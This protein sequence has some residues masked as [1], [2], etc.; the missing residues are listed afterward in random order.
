MIKSIKYRYVVVFL[1]LVFIVL[2]YS[3]SFGSEFDG[4]FLTISTFTFSIF[5][6]FFISKQG[7][8]QTSV[9][10]KVS[11]FDGLLSFIYRAFGH[12][13]DHKQKEI[14]QL[15]LKH[16]NAALSSKDWAYYF[17]RK[18]SVLTDIHSNLDKVMSD[19]SYS[20]KS[21]AING[22]MNALLEAQ[23]IRKG[24]IALYNERVPVAQWL[25]ILLLTINLLVSVSLLPSQGVILA[26]F[27]KAA[28]ST[29]AIFV[30]IVL[31]QFDR[32]NFFERVVGENSSKDVIEII[33]GKK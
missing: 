29:A 16:Y 4:I 14:G 7:N 27:L 17:T 26:S 18:T 15:L 11:S 3:I 5:T 22:V 8:R 23:K 6:G 25:L 32:L 24:L 28:F 12:F 30:I 21:H 20:K 9:R 13:S 33:E 1:F 31:A 2:F 10:N 19:E